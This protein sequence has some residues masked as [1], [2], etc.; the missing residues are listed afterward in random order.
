MRKYVGKPARLSP[1]SLDS[2]TKP[3]GTSK[4]FAKKQEPRKDSKVMVTGSQDSNLDSQGSHGYA[5]SH[6]NQAS[7]RPLV[8]KKIR[9]RQQSRDSTTEEYPVQT[10]QHRPAR[11][12]ANSNSDENIE[13]SP[14][15]RRRRQ[16]SNQNARS[17]REKVTQA[18]RERY[19][20]E[21]SDHE[22]EF[23][24][25]YKEENSRG[26]RHPAADSTRYR[27]ES[28]EKA[29]HPRDGD[30]YLE[31]EFDQPAPP[32]ARRPQQPP[33]P[34]RRSG[35]PPVETAPITSDPEEEYRPHEVLHPCLI[36][37]R[38]FA[39]E[40][41]LEKHMVACSKTQKPRKVFDATKARVRGTELEKYVV[42]GKKKVRL[43]AHVCDFTPAS[44]QPQRPRRPG[45][46][47]RKSQTGGKSMPS[48]SAWFVRG[49][50]RRTWPRPY[51]RKSLPGR[52]CHRQT[53]TM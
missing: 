16:S 14:P 43:R 25:N 8:T 32:T 11:L 38:K 17:G 48:S 51:P 1:L 31:E 15:L 49:V 46:S 7:T 42:T 29:P 47:P 24:V 52:S 27:R 40:S 5:V 44:L 21:E 30:E 12:S 3:S 34:K 39:D 20:T 45:L 50:G 35:Q 2:L 9:S 22:S 41:R 19:A 10:R 4:I 13:S 37:K 18:V 53:P 23:P 6:A 33:S 28:L 26:S 36:C